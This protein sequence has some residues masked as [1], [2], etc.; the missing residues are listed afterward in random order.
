MKKIFQ[1]S[2]ILLTIVSCA[3]KSNKKVQ[4]NSLTTNAFKIDFP[5]DSLLSF[6]SEKK[7]KEV[8]G[9][10]NVTRS[11]GY[12]PEGMG[13]YNYT[14]LFPNSK[15]SVQFN[16]EDDTLEFNKLS[17]IRINEWNSDWKTKEGI[18]I[19]TDI[20]ELEVFNEKPFTFYGLEWDYSGDI[21][22]NDGLLDKR[23][24][25]GSLSYPDKVMPHKFDSLIGD[26]TI[27]S[28]SKIAKEAKLVLTEI[29][30]LKD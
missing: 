29:V 5:L 16:W 13:K 28:S 26:H 15:N 3:K 10:N 18:T 7:L 19:G 9:T 1:I 14:K 22:W 25:Y 21:Q 30:M 2:L 24:I 12:F 4:T 23:K 6:D 17:S 8:F 11:V 20:D 27:E